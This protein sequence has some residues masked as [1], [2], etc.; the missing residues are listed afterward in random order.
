MICT[1]IHTYIYNNTPIC[2]H[3]SMSIRII[4]DMTYRQYIS[5]RIKT[6]VDYYTYTRI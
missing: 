2:I 1:Y 4:C 3:I 5:Q 6:T